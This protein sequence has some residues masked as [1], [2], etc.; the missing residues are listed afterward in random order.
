MKK[1]H[2]KN[3]K[4]YPTLYHDIFIEKCER[5]CPIGEHRI[6]KAFDRY[7]NHLQDSNPEL[8]AKLREQRAK[9]HYA[10]IF[11]DDVEY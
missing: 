3:C 9:E 5:G 7:L 2:L 4:S 11:A 8:E 10:N 6:Q 1:G